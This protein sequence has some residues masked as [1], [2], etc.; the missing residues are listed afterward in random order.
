MT[1]V[2]AVP[3][4]ALGICPSFARPVLQEGHLKS[5]LYW[6]WIIQG[7]NVLVSFSF[8]ALRTSL[9]GKEIFWTY[10]TTLKLFHVCSNQSIISVH[11]ILYVFVHQQAHAMVSWPHTSCYEKLNSESHCSILKKRFREAMCTHVSDQEKN[12]PLSID[13]VVLEVFCMSY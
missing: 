2:I 1:F 6:F 8:P 10:R 13:A 7:S 11:Q 9:F 5:S 4:P 12:G 3:V